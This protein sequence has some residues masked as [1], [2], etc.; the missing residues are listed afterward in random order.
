MVF[1][2]TSFCYVDKKDV[3]FCKR[4]AELLA[5]LVILKEESEKS[6]DYMKDAFLKEM[7]NHEYSINWDGD[8]DVLSAFGNIPRE[9][10]WNCEYTL[11]DLFDALE[12]TETQRE[13]YKAARKQYYKQ[14]GEE[15]C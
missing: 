14:I 9:V 5:K 8:V 15:A 13:A 4:Q 1:N 12:F 6:F 7:Y 3:P 10:T 2:P 11:N